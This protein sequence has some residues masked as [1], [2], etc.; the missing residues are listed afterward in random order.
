MHIYEA[1]LWESAGGNRY[2][3]NDVKDLG[4]ISGKW[5]VPARMLGMELTD[6]ILMLRDTFKATV[7][8]YNKEKDFLS[9]YWTNKNDAN[10]YK[11][12]INKEA[13]KRK[14]SV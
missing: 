8:S 14:F 4:G 1:T 12:W 5:W 13:K 3:V 6:Y 9:F 10:K 11:L 7:E 2:Y